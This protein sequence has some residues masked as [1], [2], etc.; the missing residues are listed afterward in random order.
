MKSPPCWEGPKLT[1]GDGQ[2]KLGQI[3]SVAQE[4]VN[5]TA[6]LVGGH[7]INIMDTN[8]IIIASSDSERIGSF[9]Q[10]AAE[11]LAQRTPV[12]IFQQDL[13]R[14]PGSKEGI[15]LPIIKEGQVLGVVGILGD[16]RLV[17]AAANLLGVYVGLYLEQANAAQKSS[18]RRELRQSLLRRMFSGT[19]EESAV[20]GAPLPAL[21][22]PMRVIALTVFQPDHFQRIHMLDR[23][24]ELLLAKGLIDSRQDMYGILED[25]LFI[26]RHTPQMFHGKSYIENLYNALK[27]EYSWEI[28]ISIGGEAQGCEDLA[29]SH[30]EAKS[31]CRLCGEGCHDIQQSQSQILYL[32]SCLREGVLE[33]F[34]APRFQAIQDGFGEDLQWLIATVEAYC[35]CQFSV[36][37]AADCLHIHKNTLLYRIRKILSLMGMEEEQGFIK[38]YFLKLLLIYYRDLKGKQSF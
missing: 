10:G 8:G 15:N 2:M 3:E 14:Y 6:P 34:I 32:M 5:A 7:T 26:V 30:Q 19:M 36:A 17:E 20:A 23:M 37:K 4:I 16:P 25:A 31:L 1:D 33:R 29:Q 21:R 11:V 38:E 35:E 28:S 13:P 22:F 18:L 9:H 27:K 24:E 12:R